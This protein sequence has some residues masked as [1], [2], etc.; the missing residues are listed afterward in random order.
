LHTIELANKFTRPKSRKGRNYGSTIWSA[1]KC[2][3]KVSPYVILEVF[4]F[5]QK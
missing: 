2:R 4:L 1:A 3:V 5:K